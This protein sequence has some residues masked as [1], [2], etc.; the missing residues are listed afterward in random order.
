LQERP[1][2]EA[3]ST[4]AAYR[5]RVHGI[6]SR[7]GIRVEDDD[8]GSVRR[9]YNTV[10]TRASVGEA[11]IPVRRLPCHP[12]LAPASQ[13]PPACVDVLQPSDND[14]RTAGSAPQLFGA[15][16]W[17]PARHERSGLAEPD[18]T[19]ALPR[20]FRPWLCP[21][22]PQPEGAVDPRRGFHCPVPTGTLGAAS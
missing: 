21:R 7:K 12:G 6:L 4:R 2:K 3:E 15:P 20:S 13:A 22:R 16:L 9:L 10:V 14:H 17:R 19:L 1:S 11:S 18:K 8:P 5:A